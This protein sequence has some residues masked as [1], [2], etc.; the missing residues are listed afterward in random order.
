MGSAALGTASWRLRLSA[1]GEDKAAM[2]ASRRFNVESLWTNLK[3]A[4]N[5]LQMVIE[6]FF[7]VSEGLRKITDIVV[8]SFEARNDLLADGQRIHVLFLSFGHRLGCR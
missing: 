7:T 5:M 3:T 6:F 4:G 1:A 8:C 2:Q